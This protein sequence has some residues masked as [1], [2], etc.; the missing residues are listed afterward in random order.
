MLKLLFLK[1]HKI[2]KEKFLFPPDFALI[3]RAWMCAQSLQSCLILFGPMDCHPPAAQSVGPSKQEYCSGLPCPP[4]GDL[5]EP[6]I[7]PMF[8]ASPVL[9]VDSRSR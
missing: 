5:P 8:P 9:Q 1:G 6:E 2:I 4:P 7:K 3:F